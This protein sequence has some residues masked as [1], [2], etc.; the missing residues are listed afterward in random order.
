MRQRILLTGG[1]GLL[2]L[3]WALAVRERATVML[4]M[5]RRSIALGNVEC[6]LL[7]LESVDQLARTLE[8]IKP[9]VVIHTAG[10]TSVEQCE[11]EP[12]L[13]CHVNSDL[14]ENVAQAC[15]QTG[16]ALV[17]VSTDHLFAGAESLVGENCPV[18]PVNIYGRTKAAAE[19]RV[20]GI[21]PRSLV[22]RTNFFGWGPSYRQSFSDI[23]I[24]ELRAGN[25]ITLFQ[26]V[27][28]TPILAETVAHSVHE[29]IDRR[30][31]GIFNVVGDE[32]I[33]KYEFGLQLAGRLG[34]DNGLIKPGSIADRPNLVQRPCDMSLSNQKVCA[35]LGRKLGS[36]GDHL[37]GLRRQEASGQIQEIR[38]L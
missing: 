18:A 4:G 9:D 30:A 12:E 20:L 27:F 8:V 2:A 16:I 14:A 38:S 36:A 32:R 28:Y 13:A 37:A 34:L 5:H 15:A 35:F 10:M 1:S 29:L 26:D 19:N 25:G 24:N 31:S 6:H 23:V 3:N 17:H 7:N 22:I 11:A 21:D 33:S